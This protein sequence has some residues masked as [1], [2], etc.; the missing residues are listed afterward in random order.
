[1]GNAFGERLGRL[2]MAFAALALLGAPPAGA[3][4]TLSYQVDVNKV[5]DSGLGAAVEASS[6][7]IELQDRPPED[8]TG[9]RARAVEDLDRLQKALRSSGYYDGKVDIK[10]DG[11]EV[12]ADLRQPL[13]AYEDDAK[14]KLPVAI[15]VTPGPLYKI[16]SI[17]ITGAGGIRPALKIEKGAPARAADIVAARRDIL[18]QLMQAGHPFAAVELK[19]AVVDHAAHALDISFAVDPGPAATLGPVTV[20]GLDWTDRDFIAGRATFP[21]GTKYSPAAL[22]GLRSDL[23]SLDVFSSVKVTPAAALDAQGRLPVTVEVVEKE[24]HFVGLG[25]NYSTNDGAGGTVY[26]G[27]RNLFGGGERLKIE[28]DLSGLAEDGWDGADYSLTANFSAPDF[29]ARRQ[30]FVSSLV[31]GQEHDPDTFDKTAVTLNVGV[32]RTLGKAVRVGAGWET[33]AARI[34]DHSSTDDFL[35]D[36]PTGKIA[37]DDTDDLLNPTKG[38]RASFNV[39]AFPT[40]FGSSRDV[41]TTNSN[42]SSY[43]N[44]AGKGDLVLAGRVGFAN[45]FGS[46]LE[47]L[48]ADRRLYAGGGGSVRGFK[49]RSISPEDANGDLTGGRSALTGSIELRYRFLEDFGLVPFFDAGTVSRSAAP[50]FDEPIRYAVGLG[51]RYYTSFGPIRADIAVPLNPRHDDDPVA[52][53]V[54]IGQAF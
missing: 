53:Y 2:A 38:V 21:P 26:W 24:R 29:L 20:K 32:E 46:S 51:L 17:A 43:L 35:L 31:V 52:F 23:Q 39:E 8:V 50:K 6:T 18:D 13:T 33:E 14:K 3:A 28:G 15:T 12:T 48:P 16:R 44:L 1:M 30:D 7:L 19:P 45:A 41:F 27:D 5:A 25:A 34:D 47:D 49:F 54:S 10:V 22:E 11:Q 4:G 9:V 40:W 37:F 42:V 36:G